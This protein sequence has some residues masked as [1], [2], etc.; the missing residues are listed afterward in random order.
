MQKP[1]F[2]IKGE[3]TVRHILQ[4]SF[5]LDFLTESLIGRLLSRV[6]QIQEGICEI[7]YLVTR[8]AP[9]QSVYVTVRKFTRLNGKLL[10]GDGNRARY[11]RS[12][13]G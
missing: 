8:I 1:S 13:N 3:N 11:K 2:H 9:L 7:A 4:D 5:N 10:Y 12:D 6:R